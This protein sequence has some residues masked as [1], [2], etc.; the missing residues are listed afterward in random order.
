MLKALAIVNRHRLSAWKSRLRRCC[1]H[2]SWPYLNPN[3]IPRARILVKAAFNENFPVC[4]MATLAGRQLGSSRP[5]FSFLRRMVQ[6]VVQRIDNAFPNG[7]RQAWSG[8]TLAS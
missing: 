1:F 8:T 2:G 4:V 3:K 6:A 7:Y 5:P